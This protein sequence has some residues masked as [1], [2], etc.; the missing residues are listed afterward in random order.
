MTNKPEF[1]YGF[2]KPSDLYQTLK[3]D[4]QEIDKESTPD[5]VFNFALTAYHL[6]EDW[7]RKSGAPKEVKKKIKDF[8]VNATDI[9]PFN[10]C[11]DIANGSKHF[12]LDGKNKAKKVVKD[13]NTQQAGYGYRYGSFYG[14]AE[15]AIK[16]ETNDGVEFDMHFIK[17]EI[18]DFCDDLFENHNIP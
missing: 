12:F 11:R 17:K 8:Q 16:I 7:I 3:R 10:I 13:I 15:H 9:N 2:E 6:L 14:G 4:A 18:M 5:R 1:S